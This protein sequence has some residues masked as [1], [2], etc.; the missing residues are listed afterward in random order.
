ME[1]NGRPCVQF[2][3]ISPFN[4][5]VK[6]DAIRPLSDDKMHRFDIISNQSDL[7]L[8]RYKY[9]F[10]P[11]L[12]SC[13]LLFCT[14]PAFLY[15]IL[16]FSSFFFVQIRQSNLIIIY[17]FLLHLADAHF[18]FAAFRFWKEC[19]LSEGR[20]KIASEIARNWFS[21]F[22]WFGLIGVCAHF[23]CS[24]QDTSA[25]CSAYITSKDTT[26]YFDTHLHTHA[27]RERAEKRMGKKENYC[28]RVRIF[29]FSSAI[30]LLL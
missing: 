8:G 26:F 9:D 12:F 7:V 4:A 3:G 10:P 28:D 23:L 30:I 20:L 15:L 25:S 1:L 22:V 13:P 29:H 14:K 2:F 11:H 16:S 5:N 21:S 19:D 27:E 17:D 18:F 6:D 24:D